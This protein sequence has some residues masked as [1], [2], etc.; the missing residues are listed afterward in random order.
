MVS[1]LVEEVRIHPVEGEV[2]PVI[3]AVQETG[4]DRLQRI[5]EEDASRGL[6]EVDEAVEE[7]HMVEIVDRRVEIA[8]VVVVVESFLHEDSEGLIPWVTG[9]VG[10]SEHYGSW[11]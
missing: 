10:Q 5:P 8:S 4:T 6:L 3:T 7:D 2:N 9:V 1:F 11:R